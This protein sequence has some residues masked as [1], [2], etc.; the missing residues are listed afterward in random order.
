MA[1]LCLYYVC[2]SHDAWTLKSPY[3]P[4]QYAIFQCLGI[5]L[6]WCSKFK[7]ICGAAVVI[8]SNTPDVCFSCLWALPII[9]TYENLNCPFIPIFGMVA[10][11]CVWHLL[12]RECTTNH[13]QVQNRDKIWHWVKRRCLILIS[14][15]VDPRC[16]RCAAHE[17]MS[18]TVADI[19]CMHAGLKN[20]E[21]MIQ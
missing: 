4:H 8:T 5:D 6:Q 14:E 13:T 15:A 18:H 2:R 12:L 21:Q 11:W 3:S 7:L 9:T 17:V 10:G 20:N 16:P 1:T 19:E